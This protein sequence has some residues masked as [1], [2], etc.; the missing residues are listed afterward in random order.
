MMAIGEN[1]M[2]TRHQESP[3]EQGVLFFIYFSRIYVYTVPTTVRRDGEADTYRVF[4]VPQHM[5]MVGIIR[6]STLK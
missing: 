1:Q 3:L 6:Q 4:S 5:R 2:P